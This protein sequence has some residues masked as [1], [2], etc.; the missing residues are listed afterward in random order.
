MSSLDELDELRRVLD[1][2]RASL[3]AEVDRAAAVLGAS[4]SRPG[5]KVLACG[6]GGSAASAQHFV[7][8][9]VGRY[10]VDRPA[11]SALALSADTVTLTAV[12]NDSDFSQVFARQ[13]EALAR[14]G[15]VLVAISTSGRSPN[16]LRAARSARLLGCAVVAL[17]G[18]APEAPLAALADAVIS[19]PSDSVAR[20]QEVHALALHALALALEQDALSRDRG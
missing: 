1:E 20:I 17:T 15:D 18:R 9:L 16:V 3:P 7:A 4:L 2:A 5:S 19:V 6:N 12:S 14:P 11:L 8:E 13:V 10:R